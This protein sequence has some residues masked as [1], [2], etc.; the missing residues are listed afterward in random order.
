[1]LVHD[2]LTGAAQRLE[3]HVLVDVGR[4]VEVGQQRIRG[5][6]AARSR[7]TSQQSGHCQDGQRRTRKSDDSHHDTGD[8][9]SGEAAR[10]GAAS[11]G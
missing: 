6:S 5:R 7:E 10:S 8:L 3:E 1:M 9:S 2:V 4:E 11:R